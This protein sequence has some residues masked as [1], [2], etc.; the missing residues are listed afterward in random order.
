MSAQL[1]AGNWYDY[2]DLDFSTSAYFTEF[3][4]R[5]LLEGEMPPD[6]AVLKVDVP[7]GATPQTPWRVTRQALHRFGFLP[8]FVGRFPVLVGLDALDE[9]ALVRILTEPKNAL[10]KQYQKLFEMDGVKLKF[11]KGA[12]QAVAGLGPR[13]PRR[14]IRI[15][16][17]PQ[18]V[19]GLGPRR[20]RRAIRIKREPQDVAGLGSR[21][22]SRASQIRHVSP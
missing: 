18:D 16:R 1:L 9:D 17:E 14:A 11:T 8:E 5:K 12:L 10:V 2:S 19:A 15:K 3:F 4:A 7:D 21:R 13:R 20:S 22:P 6:V